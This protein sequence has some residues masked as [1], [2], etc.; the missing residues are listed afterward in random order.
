MT[1]QKEGKLSNVNYPRSFTN[2]LGPY[3]GLNIVGHMWK[4]MRHFIVA[5]LAFHVIA[6]IPCDSSHH[7]QH[8]RELNDKIK[9]DMYNLI[10]GMFFLT[11][12]LPWTAYGKDMQAREKVVK[13][14]TDYLE[15]RPVKDGIY[16]K[17]TQTIREDSPED[18]EEMLHGQGR[19]L[20]TGLLFAGHN[21]TVDT[22]VFT[23][24]KSMRM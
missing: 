12:D 20:L 23:V 17:P 2:L 24:K 14:L 13:M 18:M 19:D 11:I 15:S 8:T 7:A 16:N 6:S 9:E 4:R 1:V 3:N 5:N 21:T 22:M 10:K